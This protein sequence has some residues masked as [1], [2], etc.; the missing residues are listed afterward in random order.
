MEQTGSSVSDRK[1]KLEWDFVDVAPFRQI[2]RSV[3]KHNASVIV[4]DQAKRGSVLISTSYVERQHLTMRVQMR[5][6]H[7]PDQRTQQ[8]AR[9]SSPCGCLHFAHYNRVRIHKTLRMTPAMA[10]G[11][12]DRLWS[13]G[14]LI[15]VATG[16]GYAQQSA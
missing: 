10:H 5:P 7:S 9:Q 11:V 2:H 1:L 12:T 4:H 15:E 6:F 14:E 13:V 8:E 3:L 16:E